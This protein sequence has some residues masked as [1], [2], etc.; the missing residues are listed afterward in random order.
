MKKHLIKNIY[1][2]T[3]DLNDTSLL[4]QSVEFILESGIKI[5]Q[6]RNKSNDLHLRL[7][8]SLAL[9]KI[10]QKHNCVFIINDD[11]ELA[12]KIQADGVHLGKDDFNL[13]TGDLNLVRQ[14][15][16]NQKIIGISCYNS[17]EIAQKA[18]DQ[19][20]DYLAFGSMFASSTKPNAKI[21]N[22]ETLTLSREMFK[23]IPVVAIGGINFENADRIIKAGA[24]SI[25]LISILFDDLLKN[26][27]NNLNNLKNSIQNLIHLF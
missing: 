10:C 16:G 23:D 15:L 1:A 21:A 5:L 22:I 26:N 4:L 20:A 13:Q 9:Q 6:Y 19:K 2:I 17:L 24:N 8:Q 3:P 11:I 14:Q 7:E 12:S 27:E 18:Y 25:A